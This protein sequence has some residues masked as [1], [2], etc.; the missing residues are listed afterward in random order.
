MALSKGAPVRPSP[1]GNSLI[2]NTSHFLDLDR[3]SLPKIRTLGW[4]SACPPD[5]PARLRKI[6]L[7]NP[8]PPPVKKTF[9]YDHVRTMDP[10]N[11]P[12]L[13]HHHGQFLSH[14]SGPSP[15]HA[16]VPEFSYCSTTIHH[17]IRV[18]VPYSWIEDILPRSDDP[19]FDDKVHERLM[20]RGSNTGMFH[21][22]TS[23]WEHSH[24]DFLVSYTNDIEGTISVLEP[25]RTRM[26]KVGEPREMRK[27]RVNP[28]VMDIAF[29]GAPLAC[30]ASTC[31]LL[32]EIYPFRER[33]S[34]REAG[35]YKYIIDVRRSVY[36]GSRSPADHASRRSMAMAGQAA[37]RG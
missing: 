15:Q 10:C 19:E 4:V 28:A 22:S 23:R 30:S 24:R 9:I 25:N 21:S 5:S 13:F 20:W 6:D 11:H 29:G 31:G 14:N 8:P 1:S 33:Q 18:P 16:F 35:N 27:A 3:A 37:S 36:S 26:E 2:P 32:K 34:I 12:N 7:D 17:N